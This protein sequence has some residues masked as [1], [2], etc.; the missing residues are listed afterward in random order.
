M[1]EAHLPASTPDGRV[2]AVIDA[3]QPAVDGGRYAVKRVA[4]ERVD[5]EAHCFAD[6]HDLLRVVLRWRPE[7]DPQWTEVEMA[8]LGNDVWRAS[9]TVEGV[10]RY[11]YTV[12]AWVDHFHSWR[13]E[14]SRREDAADLR[15][16]AEVGAGLIEEAAGRARGADA[17]RLKE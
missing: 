5:V 4:G 14:F 1:A 2:R 10:G 17:N 3:V 7:D 9:F 11:R 16:A 15:I 6:G 8:P 12:V 13:D